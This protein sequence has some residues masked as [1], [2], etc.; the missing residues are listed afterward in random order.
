MAIATPFDEEI[1]RLNVSLNHTVC[2]YGDARARASVSLKVRNNAAAPAEAVASRQGFLSKLKTADAF[3]GKQ[4]SGDDDLIALI[5]EKKISR[6]EIETKKLPEKVAAMSEEKRNE[7]IDDQLQKRKESQKALAD[8]L[9]KR[10]E[11]VKNEKARLA[12]EGKGDGFDEKVGRTL[13]TQAARKGI[14]LPVVH[15]AMGRALRLPPT[16]TEKRYRTGNR[17]GRPT[18]GVRAFLCRCGAGAP[19]ASIGMSSGHEGHQ[20]H[21]A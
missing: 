18:G 3:A 7:W 4:V 5:A 9:A 21:I 20:P 13:R 15:F 16:A 19:P 12:R 8:L 6:D 10:D 1:S 11:F 14:N 2:G 17:S